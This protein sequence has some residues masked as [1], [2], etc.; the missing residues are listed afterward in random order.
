MLYSIA[1]KPYIDIFNDF[2]SAVFISFIISFAIAIAG[3][4]IGYSLI[5]KEFKP[6]KMDYTM[7][8]NLVTAITA[9]VPVLLMII[10]FVFGVEA[11]QK[12]SLYLAKSAIILFLTIIPIFCIY[13]IFKKRKD[14]FVAS[15]IS[16]FIFLFYLFFLTKIFENIQTG[17]Y[18]ETQNMFIVIYFILFICYLEIGFKNIV[19]GTMVEKIIPNKE[20]E[21]DFLLQKFNRVF[22]SFVMYLGIFFIVSIFLSFLVI[23][24]GLNFLVLKEVKSTN[25]IILLTFLIMVLSFIF[26]FFAAYDK[27][28]KIYNIFKK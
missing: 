2:A 27:K 7:K 3:S 5:K 6:L 10:Y 16:V 22:N 14:M 12:T 28:N 8:N 15:S 18:F 19:F 25:M 1:I 23:N 24:N 9:V 17:F 4:I 20:G 11:L 21:N 13:S 26:W